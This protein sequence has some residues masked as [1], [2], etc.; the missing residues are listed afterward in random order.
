MQVSSTCEGGLVQRS[1][2]FSIVKREEQ[3]AQF[4]LGLLGEFAD[5]NGA[6]EIP[7]FDPTLDKF[8][9]SG[10]SKELVHDEGLHYAAQISPVE[11]EPLAITCRP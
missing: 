7:A 1:T 10:H 4:F 5:S 2:E 9:T 11:A 8:P 6:T 3:G